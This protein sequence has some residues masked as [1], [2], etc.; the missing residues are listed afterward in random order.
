[1][2]D[3]EVGRAALTKTLRV[4]VLLATY[5][6]ERFLV[7]QIE[8]L[9]G[10]DYARVEVLARDDGSVDGTVA[11][12]KGFEERYP[13]RVRVL[14]DGVKSGSAMGNFERLLEASDAPYVC[15]CDQDDV[16]ATQKVSAEM[17]AMRELEKRHGE[18]VPLLVFSDLRVVDEQL[19][20]LQAS[21]WR[22]EGLD[23]GSAHRL[24]S[25]LHQNVVTGCT[26]MLNR[27]LIEAVLPMPK[28][29][30]MHDRWIAL[31]A[32]AIGKSR[33][34]CEPL[35]LYRQHED[36]VV[37]ASTEIQ[38]MVTIVKRSRRSEGRLE[39]WRL[40]QRLAAT[41][42]RRHGERMSAGQRDTV[43]AFLRCGRS[44][45]RWVRMG[46]MVRHGFFRKGLL[47]NMATMWELWRLKPEDRQGF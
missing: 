45:S 1:M 18:Q 36:N 46:T 12:L 2:A 24:R 38:T 26:M 32:V 7:E 22:H 21:F 30:P 28:E 16:W 42:M 6:G 34:V 9:L 20:T 27:S 5:N 14:R 43:E 23:P 8:S 13:G 25:V 40:S 15:L 39:Q 47:R 10:Q 31:V 17:A 44:S 35:V 11:L 37:G 19:R 33:Y 29:T 4:Q 41:I 3:A